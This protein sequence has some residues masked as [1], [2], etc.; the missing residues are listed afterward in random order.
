MNR[1][2]PLGMSRETG[3]QPCA[4]P[5]KSQK[6]RPRP[7]C[8]LLLSSPCPL[9]AWGH[10][11]LRA[12]MAHPG[13]GPWAE[14][15][16]SRGGGGIAWYSHLRPWSLVAKV[17]TWFWIP[18]FGMTAE[19]RPSRNYPIKSVLQ[20]VLV[21]WLT[22]WGRR[23]VSSCFGVPEAPPLF[24]SLFG[25]EACTLLQLG[26]TRTLGVTWAVLIPDLHEWTPSGLPGSRSCCPIASQRG[27]RDSRVPAQPASWAC[28][29]VQVPPVLPTGQQ[30]HFL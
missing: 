10:P 25:D 12:S 6:S 22:G 8:N 16:E 19:A 2:S 1:P 21:S 23:A 5:G 4:E 30:H 11:R 15:T 14:P 24:L 3:A 28:I 26:E 20:A 9:G 18:S 7:G 17:C 13:S 29:S 27:G